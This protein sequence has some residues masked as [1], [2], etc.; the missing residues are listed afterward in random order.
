[1]NSRRASHANIFPSRG[2][3]V[4]VC[5]RPAGTLAFMLFQF[6]RKASVTQTQAK[7]EAMWPLQG[8]PLP[9]AELGLWRDQELQGRGTQVLEEQSVKMQSPEEGAGGRETTEPSPGSA[10]MS[11]PSWGTEGTGVSGL[12]ERE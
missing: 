5:E 6:S 7:E 9:P 10:C 11:L 8:V 2:H 4:L 1:M 3:S 12:H